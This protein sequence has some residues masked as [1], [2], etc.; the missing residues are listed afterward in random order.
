MQPDLCVEISKI[1]PGRASGSPLLDLFITLLSMGVTGFQEL[2][3]ERG[4][5][6][7]HLRTQLGNLA[8]ANGERVL[9]TPHNTISMAMTLS[10]F[11]AGGDP[12]GD[13]V[14]TS[15]LGSMLFSR[16]VSGARR[17]GPLC[18]FPGCCLD[19][20]LPVQRL[21]WS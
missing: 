12:A 17:T 14:G 3:R 16:F 2:L 5:V 9:A 10:T 1:Y 18:V 7:D 11:R 19:W 8:A 13:P 20:G 6:M 21:F 4:A 15:M